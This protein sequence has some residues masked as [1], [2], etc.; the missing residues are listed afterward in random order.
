MDRKDI[1]EMVIQYLSS[2]SKQN[3][4]IKLANYL[5]REEAVQLQ[6]ILENDKTVFRVW[7]YTTDG[8]YL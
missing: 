2:T 5:T 4:D 3:T 1:K 7:L 8:K 6:S